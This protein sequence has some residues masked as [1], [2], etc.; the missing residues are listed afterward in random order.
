MKTILVVD[1]SPLIR[2]AIRR[3]IEPL[4]F[5]VDE[6]GNGCEALEHFENGATPDAVLLDVEM[7]EMDG[8]AFLKALR[9]RADLPQPPVVM[10]TTRTEITVIT[11]AIES[12][13]NEYVMKPFDGAILGAKLEG[14]GLV[15]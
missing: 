8:I 2:K 6:A 9:G 13:A 10:C 11:E 4:G 14:I 12:G 3:I 7:P 5:S 15:A 1:D